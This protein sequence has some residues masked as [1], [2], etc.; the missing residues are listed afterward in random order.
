LEDLGFCHEAMVLHVPALL[1]L[2]KGSGTAREITLRQKESPAPF[3]S[4]GSRDL[5]S[6]ADVPGG[7]APRPVH[8]LFI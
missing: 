8:R 3:S 1:I 7:L 4:P 2:A 6:L 5:T